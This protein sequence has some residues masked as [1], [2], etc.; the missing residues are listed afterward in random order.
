MFT[1]TD[2]QLAAYLVTLGHPLRRLDGPRGRRVFAFG[3]EAE[4]DSFGYF[5]DARPVSARKLFGA[6]RDLKKAVFE[7]PAP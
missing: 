7:H 3:P 2:L 5:Q 4:G 6:H 1:T